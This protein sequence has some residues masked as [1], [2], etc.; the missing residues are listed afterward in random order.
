MK[1]IF[2]LVVL[3]LVLSCKKDK[4]ETKKV[5]E[6]TI[7]SN[8]LKE[9]VSFLA[10]DELKGRDTGTEGIESAA[11]FIEDRFVEYG[12]KP[13]FNEYRDNFKVDSLDAFNVVGFVEGNDDKLKDEVVIIGAHYDHIGF[14][15]KVGNDSIGNGANDNATGTAA[16]LAMA[17]YFA[18]KKS[19]KRSVM[20]ALFTAEERGLLGSS[21]LAKRLKEENLNLYT[22][23]NFEMIGVPFTDNRGYEVLATGFELSNM[24][25]KINAYTNSNIVGESE[26]A[27]KYSLFKRS[28]NYPFYKEFNLPCHT[29]SS[30]D[31]SNF[32]YYHHVD[33]ETELMNFEFMA[34]LIN[35]LTPAMEAITNSETREIQ[36]HEQAAE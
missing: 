8:E 2:P 3:L 10:S 27:K 24:A 1:K 11:K 19:N 13:Y 35:K 16:V 30:C 12:A 14:G 28:D 26:V 5:K 15:R 6:V 22:M 31:M 17:K 32:D 7:T 33:D 9:A 20:F 21:H 36:M 29:L 34:N 25:E 18:T 23:V 4:S